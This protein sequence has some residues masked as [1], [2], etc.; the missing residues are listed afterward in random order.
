MGQ[1]KQRQYKI[2]LEDE[3]TF[4]TLNHTP[5]ATAC[6]KLITNDVCVQTTMKLVNEQRL[7]EQHAR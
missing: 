5:T 3:L 4:L 7:S 1:D 6:N 2:P